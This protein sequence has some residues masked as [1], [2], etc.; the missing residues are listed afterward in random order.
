MTPMDALVFAHDHP[1][2]FAFMFA[3]ALV[4]GLAFVV[5]VFS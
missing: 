1:W 5:W 3:T 4:C 2:P